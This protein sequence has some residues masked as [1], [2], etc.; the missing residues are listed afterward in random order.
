MVSVPRAA[1]ERLM[2]EFGDEKF[3]VVADRCTSLQQESD[4]RDEYEAICRAVS[5]EVFDSVSSL[6]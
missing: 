3:Y 4:A 1:L 5:S 6:L 2:S